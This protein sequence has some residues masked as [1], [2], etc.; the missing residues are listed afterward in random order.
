MAVLLLSASGAYTASPVLMC[1]S[2]IKYTPNATPAMSP[3]HTP[4]LPV[5]GPANEFN[6]IAAMPKPMPAMTVSDGIPAAPIPY[7]TG[8]MVAS[9]AD[10]GAV[11]AVWPAA[12]P[13]YSAATPIAPHN[14]AA[15]ATAI[16]VVA[17]SGSPRE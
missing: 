1:V 4:R 5:R 11:M 3:S 16:L 7:S 14:P 9:T 15:I 12:I 8:S 17:R 10:T 2:K 13:R 6:V